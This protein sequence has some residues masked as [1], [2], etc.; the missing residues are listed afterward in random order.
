MIAE[1]KKNEQQQ[2]DPALDRLRSL[3]EQEAYLKAQYEKVKAERAERM[4]EYLV[5]TGAQ[6]VK[7]GRFTFYTREK[8]TYDKVAIMGQYGDQMKA[9]YDQ[10]WDKGKVKLKVSW[11]ENIKIDG[12]SISKEELAD[13]VGD[14]TTEYAMLDNGE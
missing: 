3:A 6:S 2:D 8:V 12:R 4:E 11:V 14:I 13:L 5:K 9:F 1:M 7:S 10:E